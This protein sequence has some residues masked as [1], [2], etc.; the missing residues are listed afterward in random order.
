MQ[1]GKGSES[2]G[3]EASKKRESAEWSEWVLMYPIKGQ[4]SADG[5][6]G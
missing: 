4:V 2:S 6:Q 1:P 3:Q 5:Q